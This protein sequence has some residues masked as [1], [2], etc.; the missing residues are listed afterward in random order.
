MVPSAGEKYTVPL[1]QHHAWLF[2]GEA[3]SY[4]S[5]YTYTVEEIAASKTVTSSRTVFGTTSTSSNVASSTNT[6][7]WKIGYAIGIL[8]VLGAFATPV[9]VLVLVIRRLRRRK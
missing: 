8:I 5:Y 2:Y 3:A 9:I 6:L 7:A 1:F 4:D